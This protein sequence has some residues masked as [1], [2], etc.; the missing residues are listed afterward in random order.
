[1]MAVQ[2]LVEVRQVAVPRSRVE[3]EDFL[4]LESALLD[5]WRL[6]EWYELFTPDSVY[7][8]PTMGKGFE[9]QPDNTLFYI[10]DD[11]KRLSHRVTRLKKPTA[12]AEWPHSVTVRMICNVRIESADERGVHLACSF[13]TYRS[14]HNVTDTYIGHIY[15]T[16]IEVGGALRIRSKRVVL[17]M[18]SLQPHGKISIIL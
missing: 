4:Y 18:N 9:A 12:H 10:A 16:I 1:M 6:D 15:Y 14:K 8:V 17:G 2:D 11:Y 13:T 5:Q 7:E 3:Y